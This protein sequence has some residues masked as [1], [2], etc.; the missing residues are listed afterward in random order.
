MTTCAVCQ[1]S[2]GLVIN[3]IIA[4]PADPCPYSDCQLI[5][6]PDLNGTY[7]QIGCTWNGTNFIN[8]PTVVE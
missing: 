7:A 4:E 3:L 1:L 5:E 2:D 8:I 6:S